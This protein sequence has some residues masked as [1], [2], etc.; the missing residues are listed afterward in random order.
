MPACVS[1]GV[2]CVVL[3]WGYGYT[4]RV[5]SVGTPSVRPQDRPRVLGQ[6]EA[7]IAAR[8]YVHSHYT[9]HSPPPPPHHPTPPHLHGPSRTKVLLGCMVGAAGLARGLLVASRHCVAQSLVLATDRCSVGTPP[10]SSALVLR[11]LTYRI[12]FACP[13]FEL[14]VLVCAGVRVCVCVGPGTHKCTLTPCPSFVACT[15]GW[16]T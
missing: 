2:W 7:E 3:T 1:F 9:L 5:Q 8:L 12:V 6:L 13:D 15:R 16:R 10:W 14:R 11:P 4:A